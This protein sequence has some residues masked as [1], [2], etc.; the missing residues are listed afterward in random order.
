[1]PS[2]SLRGRLTPLILLCFTPLASGCVST[3]LSA[4]ILSALDCSSLIP[5]SYRTPVPPFP[6][7][8]ANATAGEVLIAL[9]GQT[10][11]LDQANG[12]TSD[13]IAIA[14]G[15]QERQ[16]RLLDALQPHP[17]Y[18]GI[19]KRLTPHSGAR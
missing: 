5:Q 12:R 10:T 17:W 13:V 16:A 18:E 11:A 14:D 3:Q 19:A 8:S 2:R 9:D 6:L 4:P 7:I 15:C 1:M